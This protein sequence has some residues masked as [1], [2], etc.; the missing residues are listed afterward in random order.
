MKV[1]LFQTII[2]INKVNTFIWDGFEYSENVIN[3]TI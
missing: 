1:L 2:A 3:Y